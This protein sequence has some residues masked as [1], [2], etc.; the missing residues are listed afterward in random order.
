MEPPRAR[1]TLGGKKVVLEYDPKPTSPAPP[2][3][4]A[5]TPSGEDP[6][7]VARARDTYHRGNIRLFAGDADGAIA[8]YRDALKIY[9]GYVAGYRGLGLAY[10]AAGKSDEALR[11][12]RTYVRTVPNANDVSL[13]KKRID[14]LDAQKPSATP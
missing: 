8:L 5:P 3:A 14:R 12:F 10:E 9:P 7:V 13:I 11:S 2:T 1:H 4:Q 6:G